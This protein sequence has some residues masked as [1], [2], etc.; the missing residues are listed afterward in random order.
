MNCLL[1][2]NTVQRRADKQGAGFAFVHRFLL[3]VQESAVLPVLK[4]DRQ[5]LL[6]LGVLL[7]LLRRIST[8]FGF[9]NVDALLYGV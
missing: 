1:V 6:L 8:G 3:F 4:P 2:K 9:G 7:R 5:R